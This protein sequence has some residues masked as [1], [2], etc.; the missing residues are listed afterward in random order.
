MA[1]KLKI[2]LNLTEGKWLWHENHNT[3][4]VESYLSHYAY[5]LVRSFMWSLYYKMFTSFNTE[6]CNYFSPFSF[7]ACL[8]KAPTPEKP[9]LP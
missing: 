9:G 7:T 5:F 6:K 2:T 4:Q 3:G 1:H 8:F